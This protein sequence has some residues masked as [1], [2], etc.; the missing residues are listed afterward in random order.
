MIAADIETV[1]VLE[2]QRPVGRVQGL[3]VDVRRLEL[4]ADLCLYLAKRLFI[5]VFLFLVL[6]RGGRVGH[7]FRHF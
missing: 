1:K 2:E 5:L 4:E 3:R 6:A 7:D